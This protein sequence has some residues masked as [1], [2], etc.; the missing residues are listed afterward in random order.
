MFS[1]CV[2]I[3]R[4][5]LIMKKTRKNLDIK[6]A[7][8]AAGLYHYEVAQE[9]GIKENAFSQLLRRDMTDDEKKAVLD[10]VQKATDH[11]K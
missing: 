2:K 5:E 9:L 3:E 4:S 11:Q 1:E 10:A 6:V 7:I 8:A